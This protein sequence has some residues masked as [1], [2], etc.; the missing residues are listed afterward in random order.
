MSELL[1]LA[2]SS[3]AQEMPTYEYECDACGHTFER[4]QKMSDP[5]VKTCPE[6]GKRKVRRLI[7]AVAGIVKGGGSSAPAC[8]RSTPC[9][10]RDTRCDSPPCRLRGA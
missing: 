2:L 9:C 4:Q 6:C 3:G 8:D 7:S 10:G 1:V 5:P